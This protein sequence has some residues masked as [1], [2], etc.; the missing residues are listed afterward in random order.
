MYRFRP[1]KVVIFIIFLI[2]IILFLLSVKRKNSMVHHQYPDS[3]KLKEVLR[4]ATMSTRTVILTI[5]EKTWARNGSIVDLFLQSY[6][7]GENT[8]HLLNHVVIVTL[9]V[10][11]LIYCET[12]HPHCFYLQTSAIL[13]DGIGSHSFSSLNYPIIDH[14]RNQLLLRVLHLGYNALYTEA[15]VMWL[16]NPFPLFHPE[17]EVTIGCDS[18]SG[19]GKVTSGGFFYTR[20]SAISIDFIVLWNL[21]KLLY[22]D[23]NNKTVCE[24]ALYEDF[25]G[26]GLY[27]RF[28]DPQYY[29][30]FCETNKDISNIYTMHANCCDDLDNKIHDLN[31]FLDHSKYKGLMGKVTNLDLLSAAAGKSPMRCFSTYI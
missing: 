12:I 20:A 8:K 4:A 29:G 5:I 15:D 13:Y 23:A 7:N 26:I 1:T 30:G 10:Q 14:I 25:K 31:L 2:M 24:M 6:K 28:I 21:I 27:I 22:P 17:S 9:D 16:R 18:S 3:G 19:N 11:S